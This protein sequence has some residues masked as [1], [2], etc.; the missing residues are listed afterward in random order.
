MRRLQFSVDL[1]HPVMG[2]TRRT[3]YLLEGPAGWGECSPLA[4][5]NEAEHAAA[6]RSA[7]EAAML[8]FPATDR[9][10]VAV[11]AMVP[12]VPPDVA[13]TLAFNSGCGT[14]KVKV[15]DA[16]SLD[17]VAAI[18]AACGPG[19]RIRLD[20]NGAW[21][22]DTALRMLTVLTVYDI[23]LVEDPVASLEELAT[24]R[25]RIP[26]PVAAESA[27]RT[28]A[29]AR[30]LRDLEAAD[31]IVL[32]PQRIGGVREALRAA[33]A[34]GVPAIASSA[35][36][37]SVGLAAVVALA[38]ALPDSPFA[39]GA[40]TAQLLASDVVSDPL[41]P[42]DGWLVPRRPHVAADLLVPV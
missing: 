37:T 10:R 4:S 5:W 41:L 39:H 11:N 23:E 16:G 27:I 15:G 8:P 35:L 12:R 3:G 13:A 29:D 7:L 1:R 40:G 28:M 30:R 18:R 9:V 17:R 22:V 26:M 33:D 32:K 21:D 31:V 19:V 38:A 36:E 24:L 14:I 20:A 2:V 42:V 25:G 6:E 34:A